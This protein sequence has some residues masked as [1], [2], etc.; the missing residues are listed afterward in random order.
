MIMTA[1][2]P[3]SPRFL[4]AHGRIKEAHKILARYH[5]NGDLDDE[6]VRFELQEITTALNSE[7]M[8]DKMGWEIMVATAGNRRRTVIC[9]TVACLCI[10][11]GQGLISYYFSEIMTGVGITGATRQYALP[12]SLYSFLFPFLF[13]LFFHLYT[14]RT[15][16]LTRHRTGINGGLQ[17]WNLLVSILGVCL[18]DHLGRRPLWLLSL[19]SMMLSNIALTVA[20]ARYDATQAPA[21]GIAAMVFVF[22]YDASFNIACNPL[23]YSYVPEILPYGIRAKGLSIVIG[24]AQAGLVVNQYVNPIALDHIGWRY[25][26]FYLGLLLFFVCIPI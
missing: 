16:T 25:Y 2:I 18:T 15:A 24:V 10:W 1:F 7:K 21:A 14:K 12:P 11:S 3:E 13:F 19:I 9:V 8:A 23:P 17:I 22:M 6:L 20:T 5:A 4:V 26:I